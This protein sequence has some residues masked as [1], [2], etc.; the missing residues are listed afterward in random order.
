MSV[1]FVSLIRP[2]WQRSVEWQ[3]QPATTKLH[4]KSGRPDPKGQS[5]RVALFCWLSAISGQLEARRL[6]QIRSACDPAPLCLSVTRHRP[7]APATEGR[8]GAK[9]DIALEADIVLMAL[10]DN[11]R[12]AREMTA[13]RVLVD[14]APRPLDWDVHPFPF[15]VR[16]GLVIVDMT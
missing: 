9:A 7:V 8:G 4:A 6:P 1:A 11:S 5:E 2:A 10:S 3:I 13:G 15:L 16:P 14:A 12:K